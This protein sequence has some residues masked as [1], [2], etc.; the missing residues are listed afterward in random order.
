MK[1]RVYRTHLGSFSKG[2][3]QKRERSDLFDHRHSSFAIVKH[4]KV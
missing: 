3:R 4:G 1:I 2:D